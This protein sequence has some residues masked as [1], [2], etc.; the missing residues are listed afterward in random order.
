M[1]ETA[2]KPETKTFQYLGHELVCTA[3]PRPGSR[4]EATLLVRRYTPAQTLERVLS[5]RCGVKESRAEA[6]AC[7]RAYGEEWVVRHG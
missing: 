6:I 3:H 4:Y 7:A 2:E 5:H 1:L